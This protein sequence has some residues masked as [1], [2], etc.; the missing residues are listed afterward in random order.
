MGIAALNP[1]TLPLASCALW[2]ESLQNV[3]RKGGLTA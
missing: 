2:G 3:R 1:F